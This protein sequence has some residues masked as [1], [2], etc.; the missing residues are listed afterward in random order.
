MRNFFAYFA[1]KPEHKV[2]V[3][4]SEHK[5]YFLYLEPLLKKLADERG[6]GC[7]YISSD[8]DDP[9]LHLNH[10]A[11]RPL[12][13]KRLISFLFLFMNSRV[14]VMTLADLNRSYMHRSVN[15][16]SYVYVFHSLVST[17]AAYSEGAFDHYDMILCVGPSQ[18]NEIQ[19]REARL[20]LRRKQLVPFGY[21]RLERLMEKYKSQT[22]TPDHFPTILIAPNVKSGNFLKTHGKTLVEQLLKANFQVIIRPHPEMMRRRPAFIKDLIE[23][24]QGHERVTIDQSSYPDDSIVRAD[25]LIS[26]G[27]GIALSF[28]FGTERPVLFIEEDPENK[29]TPVPLEYAIRDQIGFVLPAADMSHVAA[30]VNE[31]LQQRDSM[32][33]KIVEIR[34]KTVYNLGSSIAAGTAALNKLIHENN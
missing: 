12:Y 23:G 18:L 21:P 25:V 8:P 10:P 14:V 32:R 7:V 26:D 28:A 30:R 6:G 5:G 1:L 2:V 27:S 19:E 9:G 22:R 34:N 13:V 3:F 16:A 31:C 20:G 15:K 24:L 11:I 33:A 17:V 4:Y 29:P